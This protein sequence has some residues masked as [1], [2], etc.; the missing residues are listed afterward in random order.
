MRIH[1]GRLHHEQTREALR[2]QP[3]GEQQVG[4]SGAVS[5]AEDVG[6]LERL[7]HRADV[8]CKIQEVIPV[9]SRLVAGAMATAVECKHLITGGKRACDLVPDLGDK[10]R[11]VHQKRGRLARRRLAP[12]R[13]R[14]AHAVM[15]DPNATPARHEMR[16]RESSRII[17]AAFSAIMAVGVLVLPEVMVGITEASTMRS[18]ASP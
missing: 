9:G 4:G 8:R 1:D 13:K 7:D 6:Q 16:T 14:Y 11:A 5:D 12:L 3:G 2:Q 10:A 15:F 17:A 18:P